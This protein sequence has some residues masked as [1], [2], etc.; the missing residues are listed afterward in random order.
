MGQASRLPAPR[1]AAAM[2]P[3]LHH[4]A[5]SLSVRHLASPIV[6]VECQ[7]DDLVA[8][9]VERV[10][11]HL[12]RKR[13]SP[14]HWAARRATVLLPADSGQ[15]R[16]AIL[17]WCLMDPNWLEEWSNDPVSI[18]AREADLDTIV[19]GSA[20]FLTA[21]QRFVQANPDEDRETRKQLAGEWR[22]VTPD[23]HLLVLDRGRPAGAL[24]AEHFK[25]VPV[26]VAT[27]S[28]LLELEEAVVERAIA[29][30]RAAL[31]CLPQERVAK[32]KS[33]A[34]G[35]R[36]LAVIAGSYFCDKLT[37]ARKM[38]WC[39]RNV[40]RDRADSIASRLEKV[41]NWCAH[42]ESKDPTVFVGDILA[43][44]ET[45]RELIASISDARSP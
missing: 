26:R 2:D 17:D 12:D 29:D 23:Q 36:E 39:W 27:L 15:L 3:W 31:A 6:P 44:V 4:I 20:N 42:S 33:H 34:S 19:D 45:A 9:V 28:I 22:A 18:F 38:G 32:A 24:R 8:D 7:P 40:Q 14:E 10:R 41:R 25:T 1:Y 35:K 5:R 30:P 11:Q 37:I 16:F 13:L 21:I 43:A